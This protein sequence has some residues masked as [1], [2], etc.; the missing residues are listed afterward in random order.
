[1]TQIA[2]VVAPANEEGTKATIL[3]WCKAAG[4]SIRKDEPLLEL[5]TDKVT[6]EVPSPASG[7]I[8]EILM[9]PN[10]EVLP[11]QVLARV[12]VSAPAAR[13]SARGRRLRL[14]A[15]NLVE[16]A[17]TE[18]AREVLSPA[19]RRLLSE[20]SL[21]AASVAGSGRN[22]R[23]TAQ[24]V[25]RHVAEADQTAKHKR[26]LLA[27]GSRLPH[28]AVR[29][30]VAEHMAR[31]VAEAPHVTTV[32]EA[33]LTQVQAHRA[34]HAADYERQGVKLTYTA[35]FV[36][37]CARALMAHRAVNATFHEDGLELHSGRE[38]R[39]RHGSRQ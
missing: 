3:R 25:A 15:A 4:E 22:G 32:F 9:Q 19:V 16:E 33:D 10:D 30:R 35:Y 38:Y 31:S 34:R 28:T 27:K 2:D 37:A 36:A 7:E 24:D 11:G 13:A 17:E 18:D 26:P 6:V 23:I 1:M 8:A 14:P 39:R 12:R 21:T 29:K 5:E 20:H